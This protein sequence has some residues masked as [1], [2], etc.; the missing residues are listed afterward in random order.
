MLGETAQVSGVALALA[1]SL[2]PFAHEQIHAFEAGRA[3]GLRLGGRRFRDVRE[4]QASAERAARLFL[5][6]RSPV[7]DVSRDVAGLAAGVPH[8]VL[9]DRSTRRSVP[10]SRR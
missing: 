1:F 8:R 3:D 7:L 4:W 6:A 5:K 2:T 10:P 9:L